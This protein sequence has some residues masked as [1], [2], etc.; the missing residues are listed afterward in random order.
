[1]VRHLER[2]LER[3]EARRA[4]RTWIV[5]QVGANWQG[6][7]AAVLGL[8]AEDGRMLVLVANYAHP[9]TPPQLV[10][11]PGSRTVHSEG[12]GP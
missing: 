11:P 7:A 4:A 12:L 5:A 6:D 8:A 10:N 9:N 2:R 3:L 1:M